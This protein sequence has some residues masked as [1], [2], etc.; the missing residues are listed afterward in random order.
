MP[1]LERLRIISAA[2][3]EAGKK[4]LSA[5]SILAE[6]DKRQKEF[7]KTPFR[8]YV[9]M[10]EISLFPF[11]RGRRI[12]DDRITFRGA[13][14][15]NFDISSLESQIK[16]YV[17][18]SRPTDYSWALVATRGRSIAEAHEKAIDALDGLRGIWNLYLNNGNDWRISN[19]LPR[20]V[21][22]IL[23]G[24]VQTLHFP[25]GQLAH[26]N[27]WYDPGYV[28]PIGRTHLSP[29]DLGA[30]IKFETF[31]RKQ[32]RRLSDH[33]S[34]IDLIV[35]YC[36]AL[37]D[38]NLQ[39]CFVSLWTL[40]EMLTG[41]DAGMSLD[42]TIKKTARHFKNP[43]VHLLNLQHLRG[44]RN[45]IVHRHEEPHQME[46]LV[47]HL[48]YY[49]ESMILACALNRFRFGSIADFQKFLDLP[50]DSN[51]IAQ[52]ALL[53]QKAHRWISR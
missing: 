3:F 50:L 19:Q 42:V 24:P 8:R 31:F 27:F 16:N 26:E 28:G 43:D 45:R 39:T 46:E 11:A 49:V 22:R 32:I 53:Y 33:S 10:T 12:Q 6:A 34:F 2:V 37:D 51:L 14:P 40:L 15:R 17:V 4:K 9:L 47:F 30:I 18:V 52:R 23:L 13:K 38:R 41:T 25:S 20:P 35:R 48:K 21:N 5:G 44:H 29:D 7:L 1:E 36:R